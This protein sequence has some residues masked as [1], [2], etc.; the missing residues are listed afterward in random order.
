[1]KLSHQS[2]DQLQSTLSPD[3]TEDAEFDHKD[4]NN[5][6]ESKLSS[7]VKYHPFGNFFL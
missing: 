3:K 7:A 1:M 6:Y 4:L 2:D 5:S